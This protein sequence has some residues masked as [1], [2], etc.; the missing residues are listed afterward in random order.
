MASRGEHFHHQC[1]STGESVASRQA[2]R[3]ALDGFGPM[4]PE[5]IGGSA[6]LAG[7]NLTIWSGASPITADNAR[8]NY[9]YFGVREFGMSAMTNGIAYTGLLTL[10]CDVSRVF[11]LCSKCDSLIGVDENSGSVC[12][13]HDSIGLGEDGPTISLLNMLRPS[14]SF[15]TCRS[16][17]LGLG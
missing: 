17:V 7:S 1:G 9:I 2:S 10:L 15:P 5:L 6:D 3:Q 8:G 11:R 4:L 14:A 13:T 12:Y 16:G